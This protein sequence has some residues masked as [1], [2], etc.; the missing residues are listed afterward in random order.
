MTISETLFEELCKGCG[1]RFDSIPTATGRRSADYRVWLD[2]TEVITEV[3]QIN[4]G[5]YERN[6]LASAAGDDTSAISSNV[7]VRIRRKL[8]KAWKQLNNV[9]G[10]ILPSLFVLYDNTRG[11]S[12]LDSEDF[13]NAMHG[14]EKIKILFSKTNGRIVRVFHTFG[15][16][17]KLGETFN[18]SVSAF[19]RLMLGSNGEPFLV[20]FHNE[21]ATNPLPI[22]L[23]KLIA[24]RQ[25][26]R[27]PSTTNEYRFWTEVS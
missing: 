21:F 26:I 11:L 7:H 23:T 15:P 16:R 9:A 22:E 24:R 19:C 25:F 14:D 10:G 5:D 27:P 8:D 2:Q 1:V 20:V 18:Q 12:G 6:L 3:K 17:G 13:L 4:S